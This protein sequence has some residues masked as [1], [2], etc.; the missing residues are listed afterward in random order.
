MT[1][2]QQLAQ[3]LARIALV[4]GVGFAAAIA[5]LQ[6]NELVSTKF[7]L[8]WLAV[9][10]LTFVV[11]NKVQG[12]SHTFLMFAYAMV[13]VPAL[14]LFFFLMKIYDEESIMLFSC[15]SAVCLA[16]LATRKK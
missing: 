9:S 6:T 8:V 14:A 13:S 15:F 10:F 16:I 4:I 3:I 7:N 12:R 11:Q 5:M 1:L 2:V